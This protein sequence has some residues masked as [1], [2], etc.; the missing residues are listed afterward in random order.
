MYAC[1]Y[2][3]MHVSV[4]KCKN[5]AYVYNARMHLY[6]YERMSAC[7][8]CASVYNMYGISNVYIYTLNIMHS[9]YSIVYSRA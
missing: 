1:V 4:C 7:A 5:F 6:T 9:V 2:T 3:Y 8:Q